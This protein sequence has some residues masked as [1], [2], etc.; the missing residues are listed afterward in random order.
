MPHRSHMYVCIY[1]HFHLY[2][3]IY[4]DVRS[5]HVCTYVYIYIDIDIDTHTYTYIYVIHIFMCV[6][7]YIVLEGASEYGPVF[8]V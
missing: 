5:L 6:Y 1:T 7:I 8:F 3:R 2:G 4:E